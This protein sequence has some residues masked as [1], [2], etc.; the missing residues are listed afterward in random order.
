MGGVN[1][2][3]ESRNIL[4]TNSELM[5][6]QLRSIKDETFLALQP[7]MAKINAAGAEPPLMWCKVSTKCSLVEKM[8]KKDSKGKRFNLCVCLVF[9]SEKSRFG[10][11]SS[12][13][14]HPHI[15]RHAGEAAQLP[16]QTVNDR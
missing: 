4:A 13:G 1:L 9:C 10:R 12:G 7:L 8:V 3:E 15:A 11:C 2:N 6:G 5:S 14:S 16:H